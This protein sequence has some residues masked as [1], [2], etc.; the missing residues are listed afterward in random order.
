MRSVLSLPQGITNRNVVRHRL[1]RFGQKKTRPPTT[2]S[3]DRLKSLVGRHFSTPFAAASL[4]TSSQQP[5][6]TFLP[7]PV[8]HACRPPSTP[9][10]NRFFLLSISL[11]SF[12]LFYLYLGYPSRHP[13]AR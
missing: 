13:T 3:F 1:Q 4:S 12:P 2:A 7:T 5:T 9:M 10:L 6:S 11:F 8:L